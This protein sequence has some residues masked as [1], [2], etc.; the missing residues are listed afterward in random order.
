MVRSFVYAFASARI[1]VKQFFHLLEKY[2]LKR[3]CSQV[4][5]AYVKYDMQLCLDMLVATLS[6]RKIKRKL[7]DVFAW[8]APS[9]YARS[10]CTEH[11][12]LT[13]IFNAIHQRKP[14]S[15]R[16]VTIATPTFDRKVRVGNNGL[17]LQ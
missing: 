12:G 15:H 11:H 10:H 1:S 6:F 7:L 17:D 16:E 9:L 8:V 5:A 14:H 3:D 4:H 2:L 13:P